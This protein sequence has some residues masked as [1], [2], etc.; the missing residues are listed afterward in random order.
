M[1][2]SK[3]NE[4]KTVIFQQL[5]QKNGTYYDKHENKPFTG[6]A[7][8]PRLSLKDNPFDLSKKIV[9]KTFLDGKLDGLS[10]WFSCN[11]ERK[12]RMQ[13]KRGALHGTCEQFIKHGKETIIKIQRYK[14]GTL[15]GVSE[16]LKKDGRLIKRET[17]VDG[18]RDGPRIDYYC[19][20]GFPKKKSIKKQGNYSGGVPDGL[21]QTYYP[22]NILKRT[23]LYKMGRRHGLWEWFYQNQGAMYSMLYNHGKLH[24]PLLSFHRKIKINGKPRENMSPEIPKNPLFSLETKGMFQYSKREGI[25]QRFYPD[26]KI[27]CK[28]TYKKGVIIESECFDGWGQLEPFSMAISN[29]RKPYIDVTENDYFS[30]HGDN[31]DCPIPF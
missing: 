23:G 11:G 21:W 13:F 7:F 24:G 22:G 3:S 10:T 19:T 18:L 1:A 20:G 27:F 28:A 9:E 6:I 2:T 15:N 8:Q 14:N 31:C 4:T 5:I 30:G 25:W 12:L 26:G 29:K 17:Y 16:W